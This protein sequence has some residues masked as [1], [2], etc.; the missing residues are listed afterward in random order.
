MNSLIKILFILVVIPST[1]AQKVSP[2]MTDDAAN[3][4]KW[5]DSIYLNMSLEEKVGQLFM[6]DI[7]SSKGDAAADK[8]KKLIDDYHLGGVIFS[9]GGPLQ[10]AKM[11]NEFQEL[12]KVPL[13]IGMDAEWGLAMRLDS[14]YAFPWNMTLGA[15]EDN[16]LIERVGQRIAKHSKR[17]GVHINF[18]PVVDININPENPI[19]GNR[20]FGEN[21]QRVTQKALAFMKGM[22][23]ENVLSSAKHF[24]GHGDTDTDSH[25]ALPTLNFTKKRLDSLELYPYYKM[26]QEGVSSIMV[27]HLNVP[28]LEPKN[29]LPSSLSKKIITELLRDSLQYKGLV[30]TDALNMRGVADFDEG[31]EIDL[32][33]FLAG[34]DILLISEDIPKAH[35]KLVAAY[36]EGTITEERLA[37]S[38]KKILQSKYKVGLNHYQP[39][40]TAYLVEELN[41]IHDDVLYEEVME[42]AITVIKNDKAIMPIKDLKSKKIAYVNLGDANGADFFNQ[43]QRYTE[44]DHVKDEHL[45]SLLGTLKNYNYVIIGHHTSNDNPWKSYKLTQK[46]MVWLYEISRLNTTVLASFARPYSILDLKTTTNLEGIVLGYQNSK[47]A[48][49]KVAQMLFG[50]IGAEGRLPVTVGD[51]FPEGTKYITKPLKRLSYGLPETVGINSANLN[52]ISALAQRVIDEKMAPGLQLLVARKGKVIYQQNFGYHTYENKIPVSDSTIYD[53]ASLTKILASLP[54]VMELKEKGVLQLDTKLKEILPELKGTNKANITLKKMLSHYAQLQAWIPFY[55][56]TLDAETKKASVKYFRPQPDEVFNVKVADDFYMRRD[57]NDSIFKQIV[58]SD[59]RKRKQYKYSDLPYYILKKFLESYYGKSLDQLTQEKVYKDLGANFLG[60]LPLDRFNADQIPPT[61][62][63]DYWRK[64]KVQ[65]YVHDQGAAMQG[66]VGGHAGLFSNSNDVAK[67][68]QMYLNDG[69]YGGKR[70]FMQETLGAFNECYYCEEDVRRGVGFDK[71]Q[72]GTLGPTCGCIS[73]KSFGHSGFTGTYAWADP[74][75]E[76]V[77]IFLSNR[78]FPDATNRKLI[79]E[80]IRTQI[81]QLIYDSIIY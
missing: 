77:Y 17:L 26:I 54:L 23:K 28:A 59:L 18:A 55:I 56:G 53:L 48:Q 41:T 11:N 50:A 13:L 52:K 36:Q 8:I 30:F 7:F 33:A 69:Y 6:V 34:N 80:D 24:P 58:D 2:L 42:K 14:T 46:E 47:I 45:G 10:Q 27:G 5:V 70:F 15:V 20:S 68:M 9:K 62:I 43:L 65:G 63:D 81:Q 38:V 75:E 66:G 64:Q 60:Y 57:I 22:H 25:K 3:Q 76:I 16:Q 71:P 51:D 31:G 74:E 37:F 19:I 79:S 72:L 61:E 39:V 32:A 35:D 40:E 78:T 73:M 4:K 67:I 21:K 49:E 1:F 29:N 44:I 12:S